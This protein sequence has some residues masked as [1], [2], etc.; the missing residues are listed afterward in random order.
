MEDVD[1]IHGGVNRQEKH[2]L[3]FENVCFYLEFGTVSTSET[4]CY[5][6]SQ[7]RGNV[8]WT[9]SEKYFE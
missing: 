3:I 4:H 1:W 9:T 2:F 8:D 7:D 6:A 5:V